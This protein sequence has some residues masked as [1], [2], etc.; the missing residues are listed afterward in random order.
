MIFDDAPRGED[1][2]EP[3]TSLYDLDREDL[4]AQLTTLSETS[5]RL[6]LEVIWSVCS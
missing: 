6:L 2:P 1:M 4:T 3:R 5:V